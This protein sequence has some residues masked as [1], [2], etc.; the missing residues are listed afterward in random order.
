M[1]RRK[2]IKVAGGSTLTVA[3]LSGLSWKALA[4][5]GYYDDAGIVRQ[6]LTV[7]PVLVYSTPEYRHQSSW[8]A[9]GG[10]QTEQDATDE[11]SRITGELKDLKKSADFPVEFLPVSGIK[12]PDDV[13][14][15]SDID[16]ADTLLIYAAGGWMDNFDALHK[17]NKDMIFFCRHKS[18]PV[19]LWYEIIGPRY[20]R[21][22][23]DKLA[24]TGVDEDDVVIDS[25]VEILWRLRSLCGLK[26]TLNAGII[27]VGGV[28]AWA[29]P[30]GV[31]PALVEEKF[32]F[33]IQTLSYEELGGLITEARR[34][35]S[36]VNRAKERAGRIDHRSTER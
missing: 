3:A 6:P 11:I 31:V 26:N 32:R 10:I 29:Q 8:R 19:Y 36:A 22:H 1:S 25:Q 9:W 5:S 27:A 15:I 21:Q 14:G 7:K 4:G 17:Q 24:V 28:G 23:T 12:E 20:L 33:N 34:D 35:N 13:A 30:K 2:F 16:S 18:G